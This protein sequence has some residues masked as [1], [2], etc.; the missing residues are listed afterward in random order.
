MTG[1]L[2]FVTVASKKEARKIMRILL[3]KHLIACANLLGPVESQFW[4]KGEIDEVKEYIVVMKSDE[5][6]FKNLSET[7]KQVHSYDM[8]EIL[9]V[10]MVKGW[11]P[12]LR[13]LNASLKPALDES[14]LRKKQNG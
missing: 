7:I 11:Q 8:P 10:P 12:Y 1:I 3:D 6:L 9:A 13:W 5:K 2:V 14:K 4:W